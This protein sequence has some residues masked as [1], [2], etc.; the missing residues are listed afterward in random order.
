[1][2]VVLL[3]GTGESWCKLSACSAY[4]LVTRRLLKDFGGR[5]ERLKTMRIEN[6]KSMYS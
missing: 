1:M 4:F 5:G 3:V 6:D 2:F